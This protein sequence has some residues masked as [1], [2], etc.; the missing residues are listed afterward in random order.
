MMHLEKAATILA[1]G[2][3]LALVSGFSAS[4]MGGNNGG[5]HGGSMGGHMTR[6]HMGT[7][8]A[9]AGGGYRPHGGGYNDGH[10]NGP[11]FYHVGGGNG[12]FTT[13]Q[14]YR[15]GAGYNQRGFGGRHDGYNR[16]HR[17]YGRGYGLA[18]AGYGYGGGDYGYPAPVNQGYGYGYGNQGVGY[19]AGYAAPAFIPVIRGNSVGYDA[20]YAGGCYCR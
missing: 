5:T 14:R 16:F 15:Y 18:G 2:L 7:P 10:H 12:A 13:S 20:G 17:G 11:A 8:R 4:A 1:A 6:G 3:G 19:G 9:F